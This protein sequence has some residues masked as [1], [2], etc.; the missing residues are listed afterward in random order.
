[1]VTHA[2]KKMY[3]ILSDCMS[4]PHRHKAF[5]PAGFTDLTNLD[6]DSDLP[7]VLAITRNERQ[8]NRY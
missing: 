4:A 6:L 3:E 5:H 2:T 8:N 7:Y 1:M